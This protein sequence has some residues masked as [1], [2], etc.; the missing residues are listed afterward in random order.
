MTGKATPVA[1][2][3][4]A[5]PATQTVAGRVIEAPI[6]TAVKTDIPIPT[7]S[8]ARGG[9]VSYDFSILTSVGASFG[10]TNKTREQVGAIVSRENK[11]NKTVMPD[12]TNPGQT[13]DVYSVKYEAFTVDPKTDPDGAKVRVF[14]TI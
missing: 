14:R 4:P 1:A 9:K 12:P 13:V 3:A 10:V 5:A 2:A 8:N 11:R 6:L 7:R